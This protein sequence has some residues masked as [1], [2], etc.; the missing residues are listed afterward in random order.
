MKSNKRKVVIVGAGKSGQLHL[1]CYTKIKDEV[2]VVAIIDKKKELKKVIEGFYMYK[3]P[4]ELEAPSFYVSIDD[5]VKQKV[6]SSEDFII[7]ICVS[8]SSHYKIA[9]KVSDYGFKNIIIEKPLADNMEDSLKI[10]KI[11]ANILVCEN[12]LYS[13][14]TTE[15]KR[16]I[17]EEGL[18]PKYA[19]ID[20]SKDR[21][22]DS[23]NKRGFNHKNKAPHVFMVEIPHQI[24]IAKYL[25]G[26]IVNSLDAWCK[27]LVIGDK[28]IEEHGEGGITLLHESGVITYSY[29][30]LEGHNHIP[31]RY[32]G[33][34]IFC[35]NDIVLYAHY[36][37]GGDDSTLGVIM[38]Y[39]EDKL[40]EKYSI[41]DDNLT[42][43]LC[44]L[45]SALSKKEINTVS[46]V[47][48]GIDMVDILTK[49]KE[50]ANIPWMCG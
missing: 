22:M 39:K 12:Y 19:K 29:S 49:S 23:L 9:K 34:R 25:F 35:K 31:L 26:N 13:N 41:N 43:T 42:N 7:D 14:I 11:D 40:I 8:N 28:V 36:A 6:D 46:T 15:L 30:C 38:L 5:F 50:I 3:F 44:V 32:R 27:D 18:V 1:K 24:A 17:Q 33:I 47:E 37:T 48:F 10:S 45:T 16:K 20:F 21:R 2:E 4:L